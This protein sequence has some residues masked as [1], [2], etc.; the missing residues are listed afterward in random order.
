MNMNYPGVSVNVENGN[1]LRTVAV[2]DGIGAIVATASKAAN[3]SK[4]QVVYS[5]ADAEKK[6]YT[7]ADEPFIYKLVSEFYTELGGNMQ[8]YIYGTDATT[9]MEQVVGS[10]NPTGLIKLLTE[11]TGNINMVAIARKPDSSYSPG[12]GFLDTDVKAAVTASLPICQAQQKKNQPVR[13]FIEGRVA[14]QNADNTFT[15]SEA[16]NGFVG[17]VLG[18]TTADGSAA[19]ATTLARAVK[20]P[21]HVKLG[22]GQNGPVALSQV[23]IG[24]DPIEQRLDME[25]LHGAGYLTFHHRPGMAGYYFGRDNMCDDSDFRILAHG[26]IIDKAQRVATTA[27][28]PYLEGSIRLESDGTINETDAKHMEDILLNSIRSNMQGQISDAEVVIEL[29]QDLVTT[30][31]LQT[32]VKILP[33]GYLTWINVTMGLTTQLSN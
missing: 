18:G 17:V 27:Y 6:G 8:L 11:A 4:T 13:I 25:T 16:N 24:T 9:T 12:Q 32:N 33:L 23:Y 14:N 28:M 2:S 29:D 5:L 30:S 21:A 7:Q 10:T 31:T 20:Y 19:V 26:R 1:L 3:I 15:P 22:S